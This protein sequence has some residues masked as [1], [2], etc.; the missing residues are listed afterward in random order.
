MNQQINQVLKDLYPERSGLVMTPGTELRAGVYLRQST[1]NRQNYESVEEQLEFIRHRLN[2]AQVRSSLFR[3]CKI[4]IADDMI[5]SDRGKTGRVGREKYDAFKSAIQCGLF[6]IGLVFDLS[7]L[8]R[9]LG[10][11]LDAYDLAH[12]YNVETISVSEGIS[13]HTEGARIH[14]IAKGMA[15]EMYSES[16]SRQTKRGLELRAISGKSTGHNP[17][18]YSSVYEDPNRP[19]DI[20]EPHN[21]KVIINEEQAK[22]IGR[23]FELYD[24]SSV[25]V[26][27]IA[28][29]LN[30]DGIP[31][32][33]RRSWTGGSIRLILRQPKYIGI[34]IYG[35]THIKRD[36]AKD[37]LI[38][39]PRPQNEWIVKTY[40]HL[41][42]VPQTLW[43][44]VQVKFKE[45]EETRRNARNKPE[46]IWG[47][48]RGAANHLFTGTM[49][50]GSCGGNF[51]SMSGRHGG[52]FGCRN[53]YRRGTCD[54]RRLVQTEWIN[55]TLTGLIRNWIDDP[56]SM[57]VVCK[58]AN[59]RIKERLSVVPTQIREVMQEL[60]KVQKALDNLVDY[61]VQGN[62]SESVS[63]AIGRQEQRKKMLEAQLQN[64]K[65]R[66][67]SGP[68][69][70]PYAVKPMLINLDEILTK[71]VVQA[72]AY[73][74]GLFPE[75]MKMTLKKE[76]RSTFY[77]AAGRVNLTKL[78]RFAMRGGSITLRT[79]FDC[80]SRPSTAGP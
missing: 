54:N 77:E 61:I 10:S 66:E 75:Q 60:G 36:S 13:S 56:R 78:M 15:N 14:F 49:R 55:A 29:I 11:L 16:T 47:K 24:A 40:E 8:T 71:D 50:C 64:L 1:V 12:A 27:G 43:D 65:A 53:A 68:L 63:S 46:S 79:V 39:V 9:E 25:G 41:R 34:W 70:T 67:P 42:I 20:R 59:D 21:K 7:R 33:S 62:A 58:N 17:Y 4:V 35:K 45:V 6:K 69:L 52:Y 73:F 26:D 37:R 2:T 19:R 80:A 44:R 72:N 74:K 51:I 30:A 23:I 28:K 5:F 57:E 48:S 3:E 18:G 32:A 76:G 22:V 38:H 31:S